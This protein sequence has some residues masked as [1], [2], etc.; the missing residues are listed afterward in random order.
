MRDTG[1]R[2]RPKS[3]PRSCNE[4]SLS[5]ERHAGTFECNN[6]KDGPRPVGWDQANQ[7]IGQR[8]IL[9]LRKEGLSPLSQLSP[10]SAAFSM[11]RS[12]AIMEIMASTMT[13]APY[14]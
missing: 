4:D 2:T 7:G 14:T 5:G 1:V 8:R 6:T 10:S 9:H 11:L 13:T 12:D 3:R